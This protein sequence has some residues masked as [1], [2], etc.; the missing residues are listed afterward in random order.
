MEGDDNVDGKP[1]EEQNAKQE[2][3]VQSRRKRQDSTVHF[4]QENEDDSDVNSKK[5]S[6][7]ANVRFLGAFAPVCQTDLECPGQVKCC[8]DLLKNVCKQPVFFLG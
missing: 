4:P 7:E 8:G 2:E 5:E 3:G 1:T 6:S